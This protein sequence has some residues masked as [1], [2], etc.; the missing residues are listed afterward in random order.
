MALGVWQRVTNSFLNV[1]TWRKLSPQGASL[2]G[3]CNFFNPCVFEG[4]FNLSASDSFTLKSSKKKKSFVLCYLLV[5]KLE[6][7][8]ETVSSPG[9]GPKPDTRLRPASAW[10]ANSGRLFLWV[11]LRGNG[12]LHFNPQLPCPHHPMHTHSQTLTL[13]HPTTELCLVRD[14]WNRMPE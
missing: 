1:L 10:I 6:S 4:K 3:D 12:S 8:L 14:Q 11:T 7:N 2:S 13:T 5:S 9:K